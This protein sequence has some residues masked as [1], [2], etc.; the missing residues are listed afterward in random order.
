[1]RLGNKHMAITP[2]N[3]GLSRK[4]Y[5]AGMAEYS[6]LMSASADA[7]HK[8]DYTKA[9]ALAKQAIV[10]IDDLMSRLELD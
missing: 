1:M 3:E 6:R 2:T 7:E 8:H 9:V 4:E 5:E 10:L